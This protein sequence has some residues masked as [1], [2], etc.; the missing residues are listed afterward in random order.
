[1]PLPLVTTIKKQTLINTRLE[2]HL[3]EYLN[4]LRWDMVD[5]IYY[6]V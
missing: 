2:V 5:S 3:A 1:M 6:Q 4:F